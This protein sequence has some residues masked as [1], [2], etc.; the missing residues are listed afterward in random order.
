M[1]DISLTVSVSAVIAVI[2]GELTGILWYTNASPWGRRL[3]DRYTV[4]A[5]L[6]NIGLVFALEY[7]MK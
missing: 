5:L 1:S 4:P 7:V 2:I 3:M 6:C